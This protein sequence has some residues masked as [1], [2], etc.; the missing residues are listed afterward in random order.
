MGSTSKPAQDGKLLLGYGEH[1]AVAASSECWHISS[2]RDVFLLRWQIGLFPKHERWHLQSLS[3][4]CGSCPG[5][6]RGWC[7]SAQAAALLLG[8]V[9]R[10]GSRICASHNG[11]LLA[12]SVTPGDTER[13]SIFTCRAE[14]W[15]GIMGSCSTSGSLPAPGKYTQSSQLHRWPS[16]EAHLEAGSALGCCVCVQTHRHC[17]LCPSVCPASPTGHGMSLLRATAVPLPA[18]PLPAVLPPLAPSQHSRAGGVSTLWVSRVFLSF[19]SLVAIPNQVPQS[20]DP[21][22]CSLTKHESYQ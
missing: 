14:L 16:W 3:S 7:K 1:W 2:L 4:L 11:Q 22:V 5:A 21:E 20:L 15:A 10:A 13:W 19:Q 9:S 8:A 12:P 6:S 18:V 17:M